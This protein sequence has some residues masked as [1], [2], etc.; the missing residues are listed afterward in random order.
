MVSFYAFINENSSEE[1][2]YSYKEINNS[3]EEII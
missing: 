1:V 3:E 2:R